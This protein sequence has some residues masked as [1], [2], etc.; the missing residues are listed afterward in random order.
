VL[1]KQILDVERVDGLCIG[2]RTRAHGD[3]AIQVATAWVGLLV[4]PMQICIMRPMRDPLTFTR[5]LRRQ[6]GRH[7]CAIIEG[8]PQNEACVF[9]R[10]S[11]PD[12]S[13]LRA[14]AAHRFTA[15]RLLRAI[16]DSG[17]HVSIAIHAMQRR[18]KETPTITV[19]RYDRYGRLVDP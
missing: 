8:W 2:I 18:F 3:A 5:E 17:H 4:D 16:A 15:D 1:A 6:L 12:V 14:G 10:L 11:Q 13:R 9:V 19:L 7:V